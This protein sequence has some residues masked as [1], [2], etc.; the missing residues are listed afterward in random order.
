[1]GMWSSDDSNG[2]KVE[3]P[4]FSTSPYIFIRDKGRVSLL[5]CLLTSIWLIYLVLFFVF[6][7]EL[8]FSSIFHSGTFG[9]RSIQIISLVKPFIDL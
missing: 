5:N 2:L 7:I 3:A 8:L 1:M 4:T 9:L 6:Y